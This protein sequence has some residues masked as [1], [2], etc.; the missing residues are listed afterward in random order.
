MKSNIAKLKHCLVAALALVM[1]FACFMLASCGKKIEA[2][3]YQATVT[4]DKA[5]SETQKYGVSVTIYVDEDGVIWTIDASAPDKDHAFTNQFTWTVSGSKFTAQFSGEWTVAEFAKIN[6]GVD[7]TG[8]P[9][10]PGDGSSVTHPTK[11][12]MVLYDAE[13]ACGV[14]ILCI[15]KIIADNNLA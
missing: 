7:S 2:G 5:Y 9:L 6:V 4:Y 1:C 10:T 12:V 15:Q 14:V 8:F 3:E 11:D 13:A